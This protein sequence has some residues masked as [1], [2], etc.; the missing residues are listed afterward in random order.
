[1]IIFD[2]EDSSLEMRPDHPYSQ[3]MNYYFN[4]NLSVSDLPFIV[5][6]LPFSGLFDFA[7]S[8]KS[9]LSKIHRLCNV[10]NS[11]LIYEPLSLKDSLSIIET[12]RD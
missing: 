11:R 10:L 6:L 2:L 7:V 8:R 9:V 5:T 4:S 3:I 1:M 12:L